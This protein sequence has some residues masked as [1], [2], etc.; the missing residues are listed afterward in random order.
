MGGFIADSIGW[1]WYVEYDF[2]LPF[3]G[4]FRCGLFLNRVP[5]MLLAIVPVIVWL[6]SSK[7]DMVG[8][9]SKRK[10]LHFPGTLLLIAT[11]ISLLLGLDR[12]NNDSLIDPVTTVLL[13][14]FPMLLA[15]F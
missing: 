9:R 10:R 14:M 15:A 12:G 11:T 2:S 13:P 4:Y 6:R 3:S 8:W 1:R 7:T 5:M